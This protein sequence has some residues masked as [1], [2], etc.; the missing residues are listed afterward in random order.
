MFR[1]SPFLFLSFTNQEAQSL[2]ALQN[3]DTPLKGGDTPYLDSS[4]FEGV[5]PRKQ[6]VQTPNPV[7]ASPF[8]TPSHL[9]QGQY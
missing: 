4:G 8:R 3:M 2:L 7:L 6:L 1:Q 5:T 9:G